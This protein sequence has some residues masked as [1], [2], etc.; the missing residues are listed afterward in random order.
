MVGE[1]DVDQL[2]ADMPWDLFQ[3][4]QAYY[5]V[6]PW[7]EVRS[8]I[9]NAMGFSSLCSLVATIASRKRITYK[10]EDFIPKYGQVAKAP[11]TAAEG[12]ARWLR[13]KEALMMHGK[14]SAAVGQ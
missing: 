4:W 11:D 9:S 5:Q 3:E 8:D 2:A 10:T 7:G 14:L 6:E 1:W 13:Q 12:Q